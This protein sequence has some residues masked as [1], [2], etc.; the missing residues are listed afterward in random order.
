MV[1]FRVNVK[2]LQ[3]I[4][5]SLEA[6]LARDSNLKESAQRAFVAYIKS[7]FLMKD[8]LVFDVSKLNTDAFARC[9]L[10]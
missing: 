9:V 4:Q 6:L 10:H 3:N 8:K 7:V 1:C 2:K 5:R